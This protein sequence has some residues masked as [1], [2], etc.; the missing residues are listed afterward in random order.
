MEIPKYPTP[1]TSLVP[2]G[3]LG[4]MSPGEIL[5]KAFTIYGAHA[6][7]LW[8]AAAVT[9]IPAELLEL[10]IKSATVPAGSQL[11]NGKLYL[12][13]GS[14]GGYAA[15]SL[16]TSVIVYLVQLI[17]LGAITRLVLKNLGGDT[18]A[19]LREALNFAVDRV[20]GM[21]W[22]AV[23]VGVTIVIG[24]VFIIIPGIYFAIGLALAVTIVIAEGLGGT[25]AMRRSF[26]LVQ[27]RWWATLGR[28]LLGALVAAVPTVVLTLL[29]VPAIVKAFG[30]SGPFL[31]FLVAAVIGILISI[32]IVPFTTAFTTLIYVDL[33]A[34]KEGPLDPHDLVSY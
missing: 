19:D 24:F 2:E 28:V 13:Y 29:A 10:A 17:S 25:K 1:E 9:V 16:I 18:T 30:S 6:R 22:V 11:M 3:Q 12:P 7:K 20:L 14:N 21:F 4:P 34:R 33:R 23:L 15:S 26:D 8:L 27:S 5:N 31:L 32:V